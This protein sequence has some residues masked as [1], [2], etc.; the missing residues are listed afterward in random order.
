MSIFMMA[1][2][3]LVALSPMAW[4]DDEPAKLEIGDGL[5]GFELKSAEGKLIKSAEFKNKKAL[6]VVFV[7]VECPLVKLYSS[8]LTKLISKFGDD[9]QVLGINSNRHDSISEMQF[10]AKQTKVKFPLLKDPANRVA[11][12]FGAMRTPEVFLFDANQ[13]LIYRGAID[14]QYSYGIQK[15]KSKN[16]YLADAVTATLA[17]DKPRVAQTKAEGC[18]IGRIREQKASD[19]TYSKQ[20]SRIL[21]EHCVNC[22]RPGE[23]APFSLTDYDEVVGWSEMIEEVIEDRRMPPWHANPK[24]GTFK[25]DISLSKEEIA[26]VNT[27]VKNGAPEG[28]KADLPEPPKFVEGWQIGKPDVVLAMRKRPYRVPATGVIPY[29]HFVVKTGFKEDKW[30]RSAEIRIGNRAVVHH[31]IVALHDSDDVQSHGQIGSEWITATAPGSKPLELPDGYAKFIPA[32][33]KLIFQMHYTPNGTAQS[34]ISSVGFIFADPASIKKTVGTREI[35]NRRFRIPPGESNHKVEASYRFKNDSLV[36]A[37][38]PHMHLRGKSFRYTAK[39]PDGKSEILLDIPKYDFNWQTGYEFPEPMK[40]P[41]GTVFKCV[42]H[43]DNSEDNPSNPDPKKTVRWGDQTWDE[44]MIGYFD[45][46]LADQDLTKKK[47]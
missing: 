30:V 22:H 36:L 45:M 23:V 6:A 16:D 21:N 19:V 18:I 34:D 14:D 2:L 38:F 24:H 46:A 1:L 13:K 40:V 37:L 3:A 43:F 44:M 28:D 39:Y 25:N 33:A 26:L 27:W 29:K 11:D 7:G 31:V 15:P 17:G 4:A 47:K 9:F 20:I 5:P 10:F 32:G 42:A 41:K 35:R 12:K 8:R